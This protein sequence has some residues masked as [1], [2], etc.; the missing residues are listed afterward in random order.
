[1]LV[2][3]AAANGSQLNHPYAY[4]DNIG[5]AEYAQITEKHSK[6]SKS[7]KSQ[8][9][10][11]NNASSLGCRS[12]TVESLPAP[13][14]PEKHLDIGEGGASNRSSILAGSPNLPPR[15]GG[16]SAFDSANIPYADEVR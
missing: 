9:K 4:V 7:K 13:P 1:M 5:E 14:V 11:N 12:D 8:N 10:D 6:K 15:N 3:A 2:P 16:A